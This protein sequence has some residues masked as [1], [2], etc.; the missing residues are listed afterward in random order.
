M[1][2]KTL[3]EIC[4]IVSGGTPSRSNKEY[5]DNGNI[6]WVKIGNIKSKY[7]S[8]VDEYITE[9]G[10]AN[11]SAKLLKKGTLLYTI[12]ATLGE[13]GILDIDASTNQAI[14]GITIRDKDIVDI[15][16]L[17]YYLKSK[18]AYV[19]NIGRG[20]A[21]NNINMSML[22]GFDVPL[23]FMAEQKEIVDT[24]DSINGIIH[25]REE[26]LQLLDNL[27]KARFVELFG[28]PENNTKNWDIK[29][30]DSLCKVG[31]SKRIYQ[32]EQSD[33]GV[34]FLRISDLVY[35]MDNN[36]LMS[37]LFIPEERYEE[38]LDLNQVPEVGDILVTS[39]GTLGR[40]YIVK[41]SDR[42][43]FQDGM[44]SWLYDYSDEIT[45]IY[46][47][48]LFSMPGFRKQ[49]DVLQ[50]GST[51]AYLSIAMLKKLLVMIPPIETQREFYDFVVQ[52][53]KS[54]VAVQ[55]A[56]DETQILFDSLMQEYF[57]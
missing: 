24:L 35:L 55:E 41:E 4:D 36:E 15:D 30:L 20:V 19:N 26:E 37:D 43:Y 32:S 49:I 21:Q 25:K 48:Y 16:Y 2:R 52:V 46:I 13:T 51:V 28:E 17:Y 56:L 54:K 33:S 39:R 1:E 31:S 47:S 18:K 29:T 6:P 45:P 11:S 50:A 53:D 3:G 22:R 8:E 40:C 14:A 27:I 9:E 34:P 12:F 44:I 5:W 10:L 42:F 23:P 57:G 38:L 7:V